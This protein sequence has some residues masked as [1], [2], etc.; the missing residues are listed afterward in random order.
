MNFYLSGANAF[1]F[2]G[3]KWMLDRSSDF[4]F[5][6]ILSENCTCVKE[7]DVCFDDVHKP[8]LPCSTPRE[9]SLAPGRRKGGNYG[10][11]EPNWKSLRMRLSLVTS[12]NR[13]KKAWYLFV[14][15]ETIF[16]IT[17]S[18]T[19]Q[20][21]FI[22]P[23]GVKSLLNRFNATWPRSSLFDNTFSRRSCRRQ[24]KDSIKRGTGHMLRW[25]SLDAICKT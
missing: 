2:V 13:I 21:C 22:F 16:L 7:Q 17:P 3:Y 9:P 4:L 12:N 19:K 1:L 8:C 6:R 11:V 10:N 18:I 5:G 25:G 15:F 24:E 23:F 14:I 20:T